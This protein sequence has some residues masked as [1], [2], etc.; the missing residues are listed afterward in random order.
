MKSIIVKP[1][2]AFTIFAAMMTV[3]EARLEQ[4]TREI[5]VQ[6]NLELDAKDDYQLNLDLTYGKFIRDNLEVG[7]VADIAASDNTKSLDLGI[8]TEYNFNNDSSLVPFVGLAGSFASIDVEEDSLDEIDVKLEDK[9]AFSVKF[10]LGVKYFINDNVALAFEVNHSI[11][12]ED[13]RFDGEE[14]KDSASN[15]LIGTRFYF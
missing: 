10:A 2:F 1:L 9:E 7:F 8:F 4:G 3:A 14:F 5:G 15:I 6:G 13:I 12:T 11:A